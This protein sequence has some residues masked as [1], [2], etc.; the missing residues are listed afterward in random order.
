M[1]TLLTTWRDRAAAALGGLYPSRV[2]VY[3]KTTARRDGVARTHTVSVEPALHS[4]QGPLI[5][6][7]SEDETSSRGPHLTRRA[8]RFPRTGAWLYGRRL[9]RCG[10][11]LRA[12][13]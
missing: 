6:I 10:Y 5:L 8:C 13:S 12:A 3:V 7:V 4:C 1:S 9:L 2:R 11:Q